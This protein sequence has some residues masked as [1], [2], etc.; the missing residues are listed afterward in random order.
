MTNKR[1]FF[2]PLVSSNKIGVVGF[3]CCFY[4]SVPC[5]KFGSPSLVRHSSCK[6]SA[7]HFYQCVQYFRVSKQWYGCQRLGFLTCTQMLVNVTAHLGCVDTV[8]E[9]APEADWKK[10]ALLH[11][12]L[13]PASVLCLAFQSDAV[14]AE[15]FLPL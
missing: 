2:L 14:S 15:L 11:Q 7:T 9:S 10:N 4:F 12:G 1:V 13:E 8:R 3:C 6:T 5:G